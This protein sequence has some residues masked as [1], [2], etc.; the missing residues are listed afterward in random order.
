MKTAKDILC[1]DDLRGG[2]F[3]ELSMQVCPSASNEPVKRYIDFIWARPDIEGPFDISCNPITPD[4]ENMQHYGVL[5]AGNYSIPFFTCNIREDEPVETGFNL[6]DICF[7]TTAIEKVFGPEYQTWSE[8][9]KVPH[10]LNSFFAA[11]LKQ[12]Y[13]IHP[14]LLAVLGFEV[15]GQYYMDYLSTPLTFS[16]A[17]PR[18]FV[19]QDHYAAVATDNRPFVTNVED[20]TV[21]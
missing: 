16:P 5:H 18:F 17:L 13:S 1:N 10:E 8:N 19:G 6:F 14:F 7:Y 20:I 4:I 12:L 21:A 3:Y 15:C 11:T 2:G 9:P